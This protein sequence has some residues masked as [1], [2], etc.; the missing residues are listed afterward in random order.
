MILR[1]QN[2]LIRGWQRL[3]VGEHPIFAWS[4]LLLCSLVVVVGCYFWSLR[5]GMDTL[6]ETGLQRLDV[7]VASVDNA[8]EKYDYLPKTLELNRQITALLES[9]HDPARIKAVNIYLE[10]VNEQAKS[11]VIYILDINGI[12]VA[13]S[14]WN[15]TTS[16]VGADLAFRPYVQA[17]LHQNPGRFYAIG[18]ISNEAGYYFAHGIYHNGQLLGVATVKVSLEK[19]EKNWVQGV[20]NVILVDENNII[21]LSSAPLLKYKTLDNLQPQLSAHLEQTHQY[22]NQTLESLQWKDDEVFEDGT[23]VVSLNFPAIEPESAHASQNNGTDAGNSLNNVAPNRVTPKKVELLAQTK[24]LALP[25]W[26]FILLSDL[27]RI[28]KSARATSAFAA[29]V[30]GFLI[31]L[32]LY[33]RQR[34]L[35][36]IQSSLSKENLQRAYDN[37]ERMVQERT[38]A[39]NATTLELTQEIRDKHQTQLALQMTQ[40]ELIQSSK[41]AVLGQMSA[42]I[43]HEL[44]QPLTALR[45]MSDNAMVLLD[46]G[47]TEEVRNNLAII[48]D[49]VNRMGMIIRQLKVFARKSPATLT[50]V[51]LRRVIDNALFLVERRLLQEQVQVVITM[52]NRGAQTDH[53][54]SGQTAAPETALTEDVYAL[55]DANRIEQVLVNLFVNALDSMLN[56]EVRC[57]T[58]NV[59]RRTEGQGEQTQ[60]R[61][62]ITVRDTGT[63][64]SD[65]VIQHLFEPFFTTKPQGV[66]LGLGL[67]ISAQIVG[68]FGGILTGKN[69]AESGL[70]QSMTESGA[71]FTVELAAA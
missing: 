38:S 10:Q 15:K 39:L 17:A 69:V 12:A 62:F 5:A 29:V 4:V 63:G 41:M 32:F 44:N 49:I 16:F 57:L 11:S 64:I 26:R 37:L 28:K 24:T 58:L 8:L 20:D 22:D 68:E 55:G 70:G 14:N 51:S 50:P 7:Y 66:G 19:L 71:V 67:V 33:L 9:P 3:R 52:T 54:N 30:M 2:V 23:R 31:I 21:V 43:T 27:N 40:N 45:T 47:N 25:K 35:A 65:E 48:A 18:T 1:W 60:E 13:S 6:R 59:I 61:V 46:R 36:A 34:H 42:G 56:S 53:N